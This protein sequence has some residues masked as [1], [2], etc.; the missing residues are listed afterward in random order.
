MLEE[1]LCSHLPLVGWRIKE[2]E[3]EGKDCGVFSVLKWK[4]SGIYLFNFT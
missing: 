4:S 1:M 3:R 2:R